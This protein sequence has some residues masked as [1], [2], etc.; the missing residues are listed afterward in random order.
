MVE[1]IEEIVFDITDNELFFGEH[2]MLF[3][4]YSNL[5]FAKDEQMRKLNFKNKAL[6]TAL[7]LNDMDESRYAEGEAA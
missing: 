6:H 3:D 5:K 1:S 4:V 7:E 2:Q